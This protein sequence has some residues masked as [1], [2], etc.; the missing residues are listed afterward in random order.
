MAV[1][2]AVAIIALNGCASS[3]DPVRN[4]IPKSVE[5]NGQKLDLSGSYQLKSRELT[6]TVNNE[7]LLRGRFNSYSPSQNL[8]S[9]YKN[10]DVAANCYFGSVLSETGGIHGIVAGAVQGVLKKSADKCDMSVNGKVVESLI[11]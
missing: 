9:R 7:P 10:M 8:A 11:F 5:V 6:I 1:S 2:C 3:P 4:A